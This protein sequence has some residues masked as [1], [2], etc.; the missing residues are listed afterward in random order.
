MFSESDNALARTIAAAANGQSNR[1]VRG[2]WLCRATRSGRLRAGGGSSVSNTSARFAEIMGIK[3]KL[4]LSFEDSK[5]KKFQKIAPNFTFWTKSCWRRKSEF[6][7][8]NSHTMLLLTLFPEYY[9]T[10]EL[11]P[12]PKEKYHQLFQFKY[13]VLFRK[14]QATMKSHQF[15]EPTW[16][17]RYRST[18]LYVTESKC[19]SS[20]W[21]R[22]AKFDNEY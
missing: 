21:V 14:N 13:A 3:W 8:S 19:L 15:C 2:A 11:K 9:V 6:G 22:H 20:D 1:P 18:W 12:D 4:G 7:N 5:T 10:R 16:W 17:L